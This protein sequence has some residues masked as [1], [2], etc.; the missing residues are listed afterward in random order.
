MRVCDKVSANC[1]YSSSVASNAICLPACLI[2][3]GGNWEKIL[4][5]LICGIICKLIKKINYM[6]GREIA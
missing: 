3:Q 4:R 6:N 1:Q 5:A 2:S